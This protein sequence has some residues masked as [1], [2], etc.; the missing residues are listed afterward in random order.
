MITEK[1]AVV[2]TYYP[3]LAWELGRKPSMNEEIE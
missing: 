1:R 3:K 2:T